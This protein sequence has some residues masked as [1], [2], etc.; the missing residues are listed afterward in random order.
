VQEALR[1]TFAEDTVEVLT[2]GELAERERRFWLDNTP[3][4]YVF[5]FGMFLG[6][7]VG[8]VICYQILSSAVADHL[9]EYATLKAIGHTNRYLS[10]VV[11]QQA[12]LLAVAGFLPGLVISAGIYRMLSSTTD[13]PL[14]LTPGRIGFVL[15]LTVA[16]C[17]FSGL[18]ALSKV[19]RVDPAEVF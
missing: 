7:V 12:L 16:M 11:V 19:Q 5:G 10:G 18:L 2:P 13:L 6:F 3:I 1:A 4:G 17:A 14:R 8:T 15:L 9:P